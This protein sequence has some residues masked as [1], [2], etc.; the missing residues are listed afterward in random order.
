MSTPMSY[1]STEFTMS[2]IIPPFENLAVPFN[3]NVCHWNQNY[4]ETLQITPQLQSVKEQDLKKN[5][6][7]S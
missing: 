2:E 7:A 5:V 6:F 4:T 1:C 3:L